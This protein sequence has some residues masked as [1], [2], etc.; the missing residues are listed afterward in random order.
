MCF[1]TVYPAKTWVFH[2]ILLVFLNVLLVMLVKSAEKH[3]K[4]HFSPPLYPCL[5]CVANRVYSVNTQHL[6]FHR[7]YS[8]S[9]FKAEVLS[10]W[11]NEQG[12]P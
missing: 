8:L 10:Y 4:V 6:F 7:H 1:V 9:N 5:N 12:N 3:V 2:N 11:I